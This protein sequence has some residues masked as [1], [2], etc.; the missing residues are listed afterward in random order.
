MTPYILSFDNEEH[1]LEE[2]GGKGINLIR[3]SQA[4]YDV[5][6]GFV[7]TIN[8]YDTYVSTNHLERIIQQELREI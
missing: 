7:I 5:P 2:V 1:L 6:K 3:L 8:A 4:G